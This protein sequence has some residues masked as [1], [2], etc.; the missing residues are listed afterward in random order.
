VNDVGGVPYISIVRQLYR[1][2][3]DGI[4][5]RWATPVKTAGTV[6]DFKLPHLLLK[7]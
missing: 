4:D 5:A 2:M 7:R 3:G 1:E 6:D